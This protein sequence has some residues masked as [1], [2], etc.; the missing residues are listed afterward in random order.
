V[1]G[2]RAVEESEEGARGGEEKGL[3]MLGTVVNEGA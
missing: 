3:E 2:E 1:G